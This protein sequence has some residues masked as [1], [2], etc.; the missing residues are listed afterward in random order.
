[1]LGDASKPTQ[2]RSYLDALEAN[3]PRRG[4]KRTPES[5]EKRIAQ[6][7]E[8]YEVA[9]SISALNLLQERENLEAELAK[10]RAGSGSGDIERLQKGFVKNAKAYAQAKGIQ[11]GTWREIGVPAEVL[12]DAGIT[13]SS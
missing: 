10:L 6:I 8:E 5:I 7:D 3:R 12:G 4:R 9:S 2:W 1:M 11:Y 13:R